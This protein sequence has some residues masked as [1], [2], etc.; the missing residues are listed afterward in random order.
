MDQRILRAL[1][2]ECVREVLVHPIRVQHHLVNLLYADAGSKPLAETSVVALGAL[3][4]LVSRAYARLIL[5]RKKHL[6]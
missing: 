3:C 4:E 1:G 6:A 2:R 5:E